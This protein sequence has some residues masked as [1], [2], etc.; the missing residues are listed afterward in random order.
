MRMSLLKRGKEVHREENLDEI[1]FPTTFSLEIFG[2]VPLST[3]TEIL[4]S[5]LMVYI[6]HWY[7][8]GNWLLQP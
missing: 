2:S 1:I 3:L 7:G 4:E 5:F 6:G 8:R